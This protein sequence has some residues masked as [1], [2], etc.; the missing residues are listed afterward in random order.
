MIEYRSYVVRSRPPVRPILL[1]EEAE[2]VAE[3]V[4]RV[5]HD[6]LVLGGVAAVGPQL[7]EPEPAYGSLSVSA[8]RTAVTGV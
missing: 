3:L 4:P 8:I 6:A 7:A 1:V 5:G 2:R